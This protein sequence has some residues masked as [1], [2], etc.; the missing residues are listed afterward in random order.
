MSFASLLHRLALF[1]PRAAPALVA[2]V[3]EAGLRRLRRRRLLLGAHRTLHR[4]DPARARA[5]R[6][7]RAHQAEPSDAETLESRRELE[8]AEEEGEEEEAETGAEGRRRGTGSRASSLDSSCSNESIGK[9][10]CSVCR[11]SCGKH[12]HSSIGLWGHRPPSSVPSVLHV[13]LYH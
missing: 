9:G 3:T 12:F 5:G 6:L 4:A 11:G 1:R 13:L 8:T 7:A 2:N 10:G